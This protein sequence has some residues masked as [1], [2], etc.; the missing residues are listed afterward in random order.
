VASIVINGGAWA[1][2]EA[3]HGM[4]NMAHDIGV[5][6][7]DLASVIEG[8]SEPA[9]AFIA[10]SLIAYPETFASLFIVQP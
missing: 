1:S 9:N 7:A 10:N 8:R 4:R 5:S 3:R 6:D 2:I